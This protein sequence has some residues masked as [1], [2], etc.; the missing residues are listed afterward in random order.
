MAAAKA[1]PLAD[2]HE[3]T[4]GGVQVFVQHGAGH[5]ATAEEVVLYAATSEGVFKT[6]DA[7]RFGAIS[8]ALCPA[9]MWVEF[10]GMPLI[11]N[12]FT[13]GFIGRPMMRKKAEY[14]A[15]M[16]RASHGVGWGAANWTS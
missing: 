4:A 1:V 3:N 12:D 9:G 5:H 7:A 2:L 6:A 15:R 16:M 13:F 10:C 14:F 8:P 11:R